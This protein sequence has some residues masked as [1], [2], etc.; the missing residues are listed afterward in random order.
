MSSTENKP[1]EEKKEEQQQ[2]S[3]P[4]QTSGSENKKSE[5]ST[6]DLQKE[7]QK[8]REETEKFRQILEQQKK[9]AESKKRKF[10]ET[11]QVKQ[12][13]ETIEK[14]QQKLADYALIAKD[15]E[16]REKYFEEKAAKKR[17]VIQGQQ[18]NIK[19]FMAENY[20]KTGLDP[21]P[22]FMT[23]LDHAHENPLVS[24]PLMK[25]LTVAHTAH[26]MS[27]KEQQ[28]R[29]EEQQKQLEMVKKINEENEK[30]LKEFNQ[31]V[32]REERIQNQQRNLSQ[33]NN[34]S[35]Q[36]PPV[37]REPQQFE[38][39]NNKKSTNEISPF[40][41]APPD[42]TNVPPLAPATFGIRDGF[43]KRDDEFSKNFY[44][45]LKQGITK[46][47][48]ERI[49]PN[50]KYGKRFTQGIQPIQPIAPENY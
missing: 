49:E 17:K 23:S 5:M 24:A 20:K 32:E 46:S 38:E 30:R 33:N 42:L 21:D 40:T 18:E 22:K 7:L 25:A 6:E 13:V 26:D 11:E 45:F 41:L 43:Q 31:Q 10:E 1:V 12:S 48:I 14:E 44:S 2:Q 3:T 39:T 27:M 9:E 8:Q 50:S 16:L 28:A 15:P 35:F 47:G 29:F 4:S 34:S 19:K 36:Q 37:K